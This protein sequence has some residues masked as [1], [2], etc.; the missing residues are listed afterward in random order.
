VNSATGNF[1]LATQ[2]S[3]TPLPA[4]G[5]ASA[6]RGE[7][8]EPGPACSFT[9]IRA[10][11]LRAASGGTH[12]LWVGDIEVGVKFRFID[13]ADVA[14]G[15]YLSR[16]SSCH[17]RRGFRARHRAPA[18]PHSALAAEELRLG[19]P[20]AGGFWVNPGA[21]TATTGSWVG[22]STAPPLQLATWA[23]RSSTPHPIRFAAMPACASTSGSSSTSPSNHHL[24]LSAG[25]AMLGDSLFQGYAPYQLTI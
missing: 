2:H 3:I 1:Y 16:S 7:L 25:R 17:W 15:R 6:R 13:E 8:R 19:L 21:G 23:P 4:T 5:T 12:F 24:L 20:M 22:C 9:L 10:A 11:G 14:D 18:R